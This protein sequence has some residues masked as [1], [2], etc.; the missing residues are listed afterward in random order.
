MTNA[1]AACPDC[2][3]PLAVPR[4][5]ASAD[6]LRMALVEHKRRNHDG[7]AAGV[8]VEIEIGGPAAAVSRALVGL[9]EII[10]EQ[11]GDGPPEG[12]ADE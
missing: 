12:R 7:R 2:G 8:R 10:G 5:G 9:G 1:G 11:G 4:T 3:G 6:G